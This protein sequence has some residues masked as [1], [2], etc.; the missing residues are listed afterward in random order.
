MILMPHSIRT[1]NEL[2][3]RGWQI[4]TAYDLRIHTKES[5][6][7][8]FINQ[9]SK[10][11][12]GKVDR[13]DRHTVG[14]HVQRTIHQ[15]KRSNHQTKERSRL[16]R[17]LTFRNQSMFPSKLQPRQ[18]HAVDRTHDSESE[19]RTYSPGHLADA[20]KTPPHQR[21]RRDQ[22]TVTPG[23]YSLICPE[24]LHGKASSAGNLA[25]NPSQMMPS[26]RG[27]RNAAS[28]YS[29]SSQESSVGSSPEPLSAAI[30]RQYEADI[31]QCDPSI[32]D[33]YQDLSQETCVLNE[34]TRSLNS[35]E[36]RE[37]VEQSIR[38]DYSPEAV[39]VSPHQP[40]GPEVAD[41][42]ASAA[43]PVTPFY[44][45]LIAYFQTSFT[46]R[47]MERLCRN[48]GARWIQTLISDK[49][50]MH[51]LYANCLFFAARQSQDQDRKQAMMLLALRHQN[52][53]IATT[54]RRL[55]E[56]KD[57]PLV[58][59]AMISLLICAYSAEDWSRYQLH[60]RGM[61]SVV[62][63]LGGFGSIDDVLQLLLLVGEP[64]ASSHML[65]RPVISSQAWPRRDWHK[66]YSVENAPLLDF[67]N[68]LLG[69]TS[70]ATR[71]PR[72][73]Y[74][75]CLD[76]RGLYS[77]M[78]ISSQN[79]PNSNTFDTVRRSM[80]FR[81]HFLNISLL[82][83]YRDLQDKREETKLEAKEND[84]TPAFLVALMCCHQLLYHTIADPSVVQMGYIP[85]YHIQE[86]LKNLEPLGLDAS[87][88]EPED[89]DVLI[90][91]SFIGAYSE[92]SGRTTAKPARLK[93]PNTM[94]FLRFA[95]TQQR[96][97]PLR[98]NIKVML[99]S[100]IYHHAL[101]TP[102]LEYL[103]CLIGSETP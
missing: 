59:Y 73:V 64:Q 1:V 97:D 71:L 44:G 9:Y 100:F 61:A 39:P 65:I 72:E 6:M 19:S 42:F 75:L 49:A 20:D 79:P 95:R 24:E 29:S 91:I 93:G 30:L 26:E 78:V 18:P 67:R 34:D 35:P 16:K 83:C 12:S 4:E 48:S 102:V 22:E 103:Q 3:Q 51:G 36:L 99:E 43:L 38:V 87:S 94:A 82:E 85:F 37:V 40:A 54:R 81:Y 62:Q 86:H 77:A 58:A 11:E 88:L 70:I 92:I 66:H 63:L 14:S 68:H 89:L 7:F 98:R 47:S 33:H 41:P 13:P 31:E 45:W 23:E 76:I 57:L 15:R 52:L 28:V 84:L 101:F 8:L 10:D 96:R 32:L 60:L 74:E 5:T 80:Q 17:I 69:E 50:T 55:H 2:M 46:Y 56:K 53:T 27:S 25:I 90:W 21:H